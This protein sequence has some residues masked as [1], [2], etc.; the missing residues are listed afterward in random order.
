MMPFVP[1]NAWPNTLD[2]AITAAFFAVIILLPA[3]GYFFMV[4]D[5]RAY[6]RSLRRGLVQISHYFNT[7]PDWARHETPSAIAALGLRLPCTPEDLKRAYR[8]QVKLL[9]PDHGGD[10]RKFLLLQTQFEQAL[11]IV[12]HEPC[13]NDDHCSAGP[14]AV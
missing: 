14:H 9:H 8:R 1:S 10:P 7:I 2:A 3:L 5:F 12:A 6:L 13:A 11:A 4:Q